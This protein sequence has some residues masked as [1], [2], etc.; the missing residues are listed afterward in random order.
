MPIGPLK[1]RRSRA[2]EAPPPIKVRITEPCV[3]AGACRVRG[4]EITL[5]APD[6]NLLMRDGKAV[7][8]GA[9]ETGYERQHRLEP[10]LPASI[11]VREAFAVPSG[12]VHLPGEILTGLDAADVRFL[13]SAGRC[14]PV[15]TK[16]AAARKR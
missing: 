5:P 16:P 10:A 3:A 15:D 2:A 4:E 14:E 9:P 6:A 12:R 1:I 7:P 8:S 11:R 13:L